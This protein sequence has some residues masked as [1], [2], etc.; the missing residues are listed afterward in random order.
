M[1][2]PDTIRVDY[3]SPERRVPASLYRSFND[4]ETDVDAAARVMREF[5]S[6]TENKGAVLV[7]LLAVRIGEGG[8]DDVFRQFPLEMI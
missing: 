2:Q 3:L 1:F 4:G 5:R 6:A 7:Q 8:M